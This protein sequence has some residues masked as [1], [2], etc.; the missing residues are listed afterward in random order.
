M[1]ELVNIKMYTKQEVNSQP[2]PDFWGTCK[3]ITITTG[4]PNASTRPKENG[5]TA[6]ELQAEWEPRSNPYVH[7]FCILPELPQAIMVFPVFTSLDSRLQQKF[8]QI[9]Y[10][11]HL[12]A[13]PGG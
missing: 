2:K 5:V 8:V 10:I 13:E 12:K 6:G 7:L 1:K 11:K 9:Q 4:G 3:E